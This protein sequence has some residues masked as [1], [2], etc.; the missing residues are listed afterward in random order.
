[1]LS[2]GA[3]V[4]ASRL[5]TTARVIVFAALF[6]A[7]CAGHAD[8]GA[9]APPGVVAVPPDLVATC[10]G[11][12]ESFEHD[13]AV[14]TSH[15]ATACRRDDDDVPELE[16]DAGA[17]AVKQARAVAEYLSGTPADPP[18]DRRTLATALHAADESPR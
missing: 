12:N 16:L 4:A 2:G 8:R 17:P 10:E 11:P 14:A 6:G 1:M 5:V 7:G 18:V 13:P 15:D 3:G 9:G